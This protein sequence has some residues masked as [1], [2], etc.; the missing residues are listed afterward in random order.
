MHPEEPD[1]TDRSAIEDMIVDG[2]EDLRATTLERHL[3]PLAD[4]V[5]WPLEAVLEDFATGHLYG[6]LGACGF[7]RDMAPLRSL[8]PLDF[9]PLAGA[10]WAGDTF[11][12]IR[13]ALL[14]TDG[15]SHEVDAGLDACCDRTCLIYRDRHV[16]SVRSEELLPTLF[17]VLASAYATGVALAREATGAPPIPEMD[18]ILEAV[19]RI[20]GLDQSL[21]HESYG[22]R[23]PHRQIAAARGWEEPMVMLRLATAL[24]EVRTGRSST[25]RS[26]RV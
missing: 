1:T 18:A 17:D 3:G 2:T 20:D 16:T 9:S 14:D 10:V 26:E 5:R 12:D 25:T 4:S 19:G 6:R 11:S 13:E 22:F 7:L 15:I 23:V 24:D 21:L 8:T